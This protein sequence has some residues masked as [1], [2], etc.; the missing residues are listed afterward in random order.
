MMT[1]PETQKQRA[2]QYANQ[3]GIRIRFDRRLG[4]GND[5]SVWATDKKSAVKSFE[6]EENYI[7]ERSCYQRL[8]DL[9]VEKVGN[10][11]IPRLIGYDDDLWIIEMDIVSPPFLLDFGKAYLDH[12]PD[13]PPEVMADWNAE[14]REMFGDRWDRVQVALG[15]LRSYGIFYYDAKI[16]NITFGDEEEREDRL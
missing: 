2:E 16:G 4:F 10:F 6:R 11:A 7:R 9:S 8:E 3:H 5:G 13:Y 15:W 14:C 1:P 12:P